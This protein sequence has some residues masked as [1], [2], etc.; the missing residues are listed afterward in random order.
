M[1]EHCVNHRVD[2]T[3]HRCMNVE[4]ESSYCE[5]APGDMKECPHFEEMEE[6]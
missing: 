6:K 4:H 5:Y 2:A 3:G 1:G